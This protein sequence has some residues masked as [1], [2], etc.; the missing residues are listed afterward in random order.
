M[1]PLPHCHSQVPV[2]PTEGITPF[3]RHRSRK[4]CEVYWAPR[5]AVGVH[6]GFPDPRA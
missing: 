5:S 6:H 1:I 4:A 2:R 3:A